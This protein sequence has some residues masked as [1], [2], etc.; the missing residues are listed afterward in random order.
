[1][2]GKEGEGTLEAKCWDDGGQRGKKG[3]VGFFFMGEP[4]ILRLSGTKKPCHITFSYNIL[5]TVAAQDTLEG[6]T[7]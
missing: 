2:Y 5:L 1:M 3:R 6:W 4:T 7:G